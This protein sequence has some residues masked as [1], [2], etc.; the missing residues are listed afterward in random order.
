[1]LLCTALFVGCSDKKLGDD[2][3]HGGNAKKEIPNDMK[4]AFPDPI[5]RAYVLENFDI[6]GDG[7][8]SKKEAEAVTSI[9]VSKNSSTPDDERIASLEGIQF[10]T[11]LTYLD[12]NDNKLTELDVTQNPALTE[13]W[14]R[15]NQL[16]TLNVSGCSALTYLFCYY[17]Q[18][19]KLDVTQNP[20]LKYLY[21]YRNQ[22]TTL[23]VTQ[24]TALTYLS[25]ENNQ[26][27]T[28]DVTHNPALETLHCS[29]NQLTELDVTQNTA[30]TTL[31][32]YSNQLTELDVSKTNLGNSTYGWPLV[33]YPMNGSG[34][35]TLYLKTG[36][37]IKYIYP[38]RNNGYVPADTDI[39]FKD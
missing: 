5:F 16:T 35:E 23:D 25:C 14:C 27:T 29:S 1:M 8:I 15:E 26:L 20:A 31:H 28:L 3:G 6:D 34:L 7:K 36:W 12:C 9:D 32:C 22:L 33:C 10:F 19:T 4:K 24:N 2:E 18:L 21:C 13:L 37:E 30:L 11:N 17:N 38:E 39:Q